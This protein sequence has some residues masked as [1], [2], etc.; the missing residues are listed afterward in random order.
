[1]DGCQSV[2]RDVNKVVEKFFGLGDS[3]A[4]ILE[5]AIQLVRAAKDEIKEGKKKDKR[6]T[7]FG[8]N[9]LKMDLRCGQIG[10]QLAQNGIKSPLGT[11]T[12]FLRIP[13]SI[14]ELLKC[15]C[16]G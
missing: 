6:M 7:L 8:T 12:I 2:E 4:K 3:N 15:L 10:P 13:K 9:L 5:E 16:I 14:I 1:M 11:T